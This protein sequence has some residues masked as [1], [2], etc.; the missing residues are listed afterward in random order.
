M[1]SSLKQSLA[2][3]PA[4]G[5]SQRFPGKNKAILGGKPLICHSIELAVK[6]FTTVIFSSDC[7]ELKNIAYNLNLNNLVIQDQPTASNT[8]Q[9]LECIRQI[10]EER[11]NDGFNEIWMLLP[12]CP[13]R[14]DYDISQCKRLLRNSNKF[15]V[16]ITDVDFPPSLSLDIRS[17]GTITST[18]P[19]RP[20]ENKN[21]RSQNH[22][23]CL[24][25]V[26]GKLI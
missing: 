20:W 23:I 13:L 3:I 21:H 15:V 12:T 18:C 9:V 24:P 7:K 10:Y 11:E 25:I 22:R 19:S 4:R 2:V 16:S 6:H 26:T 17:G 8:S 14:K 5:G 1:E